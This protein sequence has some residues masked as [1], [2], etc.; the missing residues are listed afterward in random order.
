M[1]SFRR[2][3]IGQGHSAE[4]ILGFDSAPTDHELRSVQDI[5]RHSALVLTEE[6]APY[7]TWRHCA[8]TPV[9]RGRYNPCN[10]KR[11]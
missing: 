10:G 9:P 4:L 11:G 3:G 5:R 2:F 7:F 1:I 6:G 8:D